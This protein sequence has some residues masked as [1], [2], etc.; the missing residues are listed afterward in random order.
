MDSHFRSAVLRC[1][2]Q[3]D[4]W[5]SPREAALLFELA[6]WG[7]GTGSVVE[8]GSFAGKSLL[9][10]AGGSKFAGRERVTS[11]DPH[12]GSPEHQ[13]GGYSFRAEYWCESTGRIDTLPAL[14]RNLASANLL[15]SVSIIVDFAERVATSWRQ[16]IRLLFLDAQHSYSEVLRDLTTWAPWICEDGMLAIH[17]Y[18]DRLFPG[19]VRAVNHYLAAHD[20]WHSSLIDSTLVLKRTLPTPEP[21]AQPM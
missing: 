3:A 4:G 18:D 10:L 16:P 11:I 7:S 9:C 15:D 2:A 14:E 21:T 19:V 17:D 20:S 8:I 12:T 6:A 5:L 1:S 13:H